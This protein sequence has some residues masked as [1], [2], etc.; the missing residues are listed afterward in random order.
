MCD[1]LDSNSY[2]FCGRHATSALAQVHPILDGGIAVHA[3]R[4]KHAWACTCKELPKLRM[5]CCTHIVDGCATVVDVFH[6]LC[7]RGLPSEGV[8]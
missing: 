2:M 7:G 3:R 1:G 8:W 6:T 4:R 5:A